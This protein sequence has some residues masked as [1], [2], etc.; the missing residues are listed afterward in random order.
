MNPE[1]EKKR[2]RAFF[3]ALLAFLVFCWFRYFERTME[4]YNTT[5]FALSYRYGFLSRGLLGTMWELLDQSIPIS[6]M[7]Y[8][9]VYV[10]NIGVTIVFEVVM[11]LFFVVCYRKCTSEQKPMMRYLIIFLAIFAF[12]M[13]LSEEMLGRLDVYLYLLVIVGVI[14]LVKEKCE[15]LVIPIGLICV[16]I[17]QGFV[18]I[19]ANI[20]LVLLL[21]KAICISEKRKKYLVLFTAFFLLIAGFFCYFEFFSHVN[22]TGIAE[23]IIANAKRLSEDGV[24]YNETIVRHEILGEE[25]FGDE[26]KYHLY[27]YKD[28]PVFLLLFSPYLAIGI[29]FFKGLAGAAQGLEKWKYRMVFAG[30]VTVVPQMILKVDYGRYM[31]STLFYYIAMIQVLFAM[32]DGMVAVQLDKTKAAIKRQISVPLVL[33][34]YP[35]FLTPF[36]DVII[37]GP[38]HFL[39]EEIFHAL[40]KIVHFLESFIK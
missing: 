40:W 20:L 23:E 22:G 17:H 2:D 26:W 1:K 28:F 24:S 16:C 12:P 9:A 35:I 7:S 13:F 18:F 32:G 29:S 25:V 11:Y 27:N 14:C 3:L 6:I 31:F 8:R 10:F 21:Y 30:A 38:V 39:S 5:L 19:N 15:W 33:L 37:S 34:V 36:Y 4:F